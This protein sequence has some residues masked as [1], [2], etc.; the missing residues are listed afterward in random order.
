MLLLAS[1]LLAIELCAGSA[2]SKLGLFDTIDGLILD[3]QYGA[4]RVSA[5]VWSMSL[6]NV[7]LALALS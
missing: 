2:G 6:C 5:A 1:E 7:W 4:E 3:K